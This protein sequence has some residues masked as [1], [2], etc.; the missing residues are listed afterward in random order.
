MPRPR[1]VRC[2]ERT[3]PL[4]GGRLMRVTPLHNGDWLVSIGGKTRLDDSWILP[5]ALFAPV[6]G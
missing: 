5:G 3:H 2:H 4:P 6:K 1:N